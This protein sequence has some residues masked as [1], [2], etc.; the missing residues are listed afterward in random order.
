M[1]PAELPYLLVCGTVFTELAPKDFAT[2]PKIRVPVT[3]ILKQV[4]N[5][6]HYLWKQVLKWLWYKVTFSNRNLSLV[7][8]KRAAFRSVQFYLI[9]LT[10]CKLLNSMHRGLW[11]R[12]GTIRVDFNRFKYS[13]SF[14]KICY[15]TCVRELFDSS[16]PILMK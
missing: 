12:V 2:M 3:Q 1:A 8:A 4:V 6:S 5:Q 14:N 10:N 7:E 11:K 9:H 15:L 13:Y 16:L